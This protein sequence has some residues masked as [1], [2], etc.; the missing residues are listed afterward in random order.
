MNFLL[1]L[2]NIRSS[3]YEVAV[4]QYSHATLS[5]MD[6]FMTGVRKIPVLKGGINL[7][8]WETAHLPLP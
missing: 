1:F 3:G 6:I 8:F 5:K 2:I 7:G 4:Y